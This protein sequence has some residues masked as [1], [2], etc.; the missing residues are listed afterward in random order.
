[1]NFRRSGNTFPKTSGSVVILRVKNVIYFA[2]GGLAY[3]ALELCWR[4][5]SHVSMFLLGG[6][7]FLILCA[8]G[9][10]K[11]TFV[12]Q[13]FLGAG[14]VTALELGAGLLLNRVLRLGVWDYSG[15]PCQFLG[16][17]CLCYSLLW[18]PV[19]A[20]GLLF[21]RS[22]RRILGEQPDPIRWL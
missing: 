16:Q 17:I 18:I 13:T 9:R 11:L 5:R 7:C 6:L 3:V 12:W 21:A 2:V 15:R 20:G 22:L 19:C 14:A 10:S 4:G 8:L 1:M